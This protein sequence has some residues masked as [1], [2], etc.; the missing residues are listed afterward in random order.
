MA[1][2]LPARKQVPHMDVTG[3]VRHVSLW[4]SVE[5]VTSRDLA[6]L[7]ELVNLSQAR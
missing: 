2:Q 3:K 1:M 6:I 7:S 4:I 5:D